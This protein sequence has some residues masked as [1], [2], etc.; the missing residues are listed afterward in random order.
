MSVL[1]PQIVRGG[2]RCALLT[3]AL[4]GCASGA[5]AARDAGEPDAETPAPAPRVDAS[6]PTHDAGRV[7]DSGAA[8][9]PVQSDEDA[10]EMQPAAA[11]ACDDGIANGEETARDCGGPDCPA[12]ALGER[13][14]L[15]RDCAEG[16]C[17]QGIC[18]CSSDSDGDGTVDCDDTCELDPARTEPG[19]CGCA[20]AADVPPAGAA[21]DDGPCVLSSE[22][23]GQGNCGSAADCEAPDA[24]CGPMLQHAGHVYYVCPAA[25]TWADSRAACRAKPRFDLIRVDDMAEQMFLETSITSL[26]DEV[27]INATDMATQN[28]WAWKDD[29]A[30]FWQGGAAANGLYSHWAGG[31]PTMSGDCVHHVRAD[32]AWRN[33]DCAQMDF[34]VCE[35]APP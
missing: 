27:W 5:P 17:T 31:A 12:C 2:L 34:F 22:C 10:G 13:C 7:R 35:A 3:L 25:K 33:A 18:A 26:T 20:N 32:G 8:P 1:I 23:D 29:D 16:E 9:P 11:H 6:T 14:E 19:D 15:D 30:V 21:C 28:S 24:S 4:L